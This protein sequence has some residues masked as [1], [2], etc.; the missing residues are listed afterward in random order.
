METGKMVRR[1]PN[2]HGT[3]M[4]T[5]FCGGWTGGRAKTQLA[6][7][8]S[9]EIK[10]EPYIGPAEL[11]RGVALIGGV[12]YYVDINEENLDERTRERLLE[13]AYEL[14]RINPNKSITVK[15]TN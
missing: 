6:E 2:P 8:E 10:I 9:H 4:W 5:S 14:I 15:I 13:T 7:R 1:R 3:G 12:Q 11:G